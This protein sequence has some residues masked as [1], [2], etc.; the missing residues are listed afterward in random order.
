MACHFVELVRLWLVF[1]AN[2]KKT[3]CALA[4]CLVFASPERNGG[5][6]VMILDCGYCLEKRGRFVFFPSYQSRYVFLRILWASS[7]HGIRKKHRRF[8]SLASFLEPGRATHGD[9]AL[10]CWFAFNSLKVQAPLHSE[11]HCASFLRIWIVFPRFPTILACVVL[12]VDMGVFGDPAPPGILKKDTP[13]SFFSN[14]C[15]FWVS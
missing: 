6:E 11:I 7:L 13:I 9:I 10:A 4:I 15:S 12:R 2:H 14:S 5:M 1:E 8:P 3:R